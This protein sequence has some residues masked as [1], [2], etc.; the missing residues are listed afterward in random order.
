MNL[1]SGV[2]L[3]CAQEVTATTDQEGTATTDR[4][5]TAMTDQVADRMGTGQEA[6]HMATA[7]GHAEIRTKALKD[8][9]VQISATAGRSSS[10]LRARDQRNQ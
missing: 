3:T 7:E 9:I 1:F 5:G 10:Q 6:T 8:A 4:E 2:G